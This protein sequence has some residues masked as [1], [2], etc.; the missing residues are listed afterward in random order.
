M[1]RLPKYVTLSVLLFLYTPLFFVI[2]NSF[3]AS[4]LGGHWGGWTMKWYKLVLDN[5]E[6][7]ESVSNSFTVAAI[8]TF[9]SLIVGSMAA[10]A[11]H[12]YRSKLQEAHKLLVYIP[13]IV[14]EIHMGM[15]LL[16]L[17]VALGIN[18][19][20]GTIVI[21][22]TTFCISYVTMV[23]LARIDDFDYS[24]VEAAQDMGASAF[25][26]IRKIIIP[27]VMPG[28][29]SS[30]LLSFTLSLDDFVVTFFVAGP[31]SNTLPLHIYSLIKNGKPP[32]LNALSTILIFLTL[33]IAVVVELLYHFQQPKAPSRKS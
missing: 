29:I 13:L 21:A 15:S 18:L 19:G 23:M 31:G 32:L 12:F 2:I 22:H 10:F 8:S 3:N 17:F 25:P 1:G 30:A 9:I 16:M 27:M 14:P 24:I 6:I 26:I 28:L 5:S 33:F 20:M 4:S 11:I 7:W